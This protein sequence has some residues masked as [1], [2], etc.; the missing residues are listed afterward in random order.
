MIDY[1]LWNL[2]VYIHSKASITKLQLK[3]WT[4]NVHSNPCIKQDNCPEYII[5][6]YKFN[7]DNP[8]F[9]NVRFNRQLI[10][11]DEEIQPFEYS[12]NF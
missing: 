4:G 6:S 3:P 11:G 8:I 1:T 5:N 12:E 7:K 2:K 9:K 10:K